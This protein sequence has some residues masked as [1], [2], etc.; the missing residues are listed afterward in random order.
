ML[1]DISMV[2]SD[3]NVTPRMNPEDVFDFH[4]DSKYEGPPLPEKYQDL[5]LRRDWYCPGKALRRKRQHRAT[6]GKISFTDLSKRVASSWHN[7]DESVKLY[8]KTISNIGNTKH[9]KETRT[10]DEV[11]TVFA[12]VEPSKNRST[13]KSKAPKPKVEQLDATTYEG[14]MCKEISPIIGPLSCTDPKAD[15]HIA[16]Q[17]DA[18]AYAEVLLCKEISQIT[19]SFVS[20]P[21]PM[22]VYSMPDTELSSSLLRGIVAE[23]VQ[24]QG[25]SS[26]NEVGFVDMLDDEIYDIWS[27]SDENAD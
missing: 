18:T 1:L 23:H 9:K 22:S 12:V 27:S 13:Y 6:H 11:L 26:K 25:F 19:P 4:S 21:E 2:L 10:N 7:S 8:C 3:L 16:S 15:S 5:I 20:L 14:I 24:S 17:S